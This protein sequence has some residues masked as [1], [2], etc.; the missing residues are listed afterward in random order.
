MLSGFVDVPK[1]HPHLTPPLPPLRKSSR[2][3]ILGAFEFYYARDDLRPL[4]LGEGRG[5][6]VGM[7]EGR[8]LAR[9]QGCRQNQMSSK[10]NRGWQK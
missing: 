6:E 8:C 3:G 1:F 4:P 5:G 7:D 10:E 2:G 9:E